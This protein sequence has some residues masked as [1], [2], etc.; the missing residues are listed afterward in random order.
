MTSPTQRT[1]AHC[2]KLGFRVQVVERWVPFRGTDP[3]T[4]EPRRGGVRQD[5]FGCIDL[6]ALDG[7]PGVLGIQACAASSA[8]ARMA[9][10]LCECDALMEWLRVGN[11]FEVWGWAKRGPAGKRKLWTVRRVALNHAGEQ[12]VVEQ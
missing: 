1:L 6:V 12:Y 10:A 2:R 9:K 3:E 8:A 4:G 7:L 5:L 11:R